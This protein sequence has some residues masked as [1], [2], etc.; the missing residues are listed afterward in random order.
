MFCCLIVALIGF[1][2]EVVSNKDTFKGAVIDFRVVSVEDKNKG[3]TPNFTY[4]G[5]C[6]QG[7]NCSRLYNKECHCLAIQWAF[8]HQ[9]MML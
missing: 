8:I 3:L 5:D 1:G 9:G 4:V 6:S 2:I 7:G